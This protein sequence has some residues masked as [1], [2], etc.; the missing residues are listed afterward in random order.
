M[1]GDGEDIEIGL[2]FDPAQQLI[3][4][5]VPVAPE[6]VAGMGV[7]VGFAERGIRH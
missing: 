3:N 1:I 7:K 4:P 2:L 6:V 5:L